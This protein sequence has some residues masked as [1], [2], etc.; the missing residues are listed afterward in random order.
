MRRD[1]PSTRFSTPTGLLDNFDPALLVY[2]GDEPPLVDNTTV[3]PTVTPVTKRTPE[4]FRR[5][6]KRANL[7]GNPRQC[8]FVGEDAHEREVAS[9]AGWRVCP[10]PL[11]VNEVLA[12][13]ALRFVRLTVPPDRLR[14]PW[15]DELQKRPVVPQQFAGENGGTVYALTSDEAAGELGA[16]GFEVDLLGEAGL[17]ETADLYLLR[18]DMA[19]QSGFLSSRGEAARTFAAT[20]GGQR[21]LKYLPDGTV[22]AALSGDR[23]PDGVH[24]HGARHGH[25]VKL[26]PDPLLWDESPPTG[27]L[28]RRAGLTAR[29]FGAVETPAEITRIAAGEMR[30]AVERYSGLRPLDGSQA[31]KVTSRHIRHADNGRVVTQL[32]A[33]LEAAGQGRL[34]VRLHRFTHAGLPLFNVEAELT[35]DSP[36]LVLITA[37]LDSTAAE[38]E[39]YDPA[40]DPAPG[41]DDD[42]SGVA[43]VLTIA[44]RFATLAATATPARTVRF[45]LFNAEEQG[46][47]G[48]QAY[49][50]RSKSRGEAI[51]A[52][53]QMDMI[54]FNKLAPRS[55]EVH[56]GFEGAPAVEAR[57]RR[58]AE[59]LR[60]IAPRVSPDLP[61]AQIYDSATAPEGDPAAGRS[62]HA[63]FQAQGYAACVVSEDFFVG[64][65][66]NGPLPEANPNYHGP[67]DTFIDDVYAAD[68]ARALAAAAWETAS[69]AETLRARRLSS[70][71]PLEVTMPATREYDSRKRPASSAPAT[72]AALVARPA[73]AGRTNTMTGSPA[74]LAA[75]PGPQADKTFVERAVDFMKSQPVLTGFAGMH[76]PEFT[77]DPVVQKTSAGAAVVNLKQMFQGLP[78]FQMARS[79]R[80][81]PD[82]HIM[83]AAG[84]SASIP[85]GTSTDPKLGVE[86]AVFKAA[87]HIAT[88]GCGRARP[89]HVR[90]GEFRWRPST[91][92]GSSPRSSP[93]SRFRPDRPCSTRVRSRIQSRPIW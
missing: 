28:K 36:E 34:Q 79:V 87:S 8:L 56:A 38:H 60:D 32:T 53:W 52:V 5:A 68:I 16:M 39:P 25:T 57:S 88:T 13:H 73:A 78:V 72:R 48:S 41:A 18:D 11:L 49:A 93:V 58:L 55:W 19:A 15:R 29:E 74:I 80:F 23:G 69:H 50:R 30:D 47:I 65:G 83:D 22:V 76:T 26:T 51:V 82:G 84:D 71:S 90:A 1:R 33:D 9:T 77:P 75:A 6:A 40:A 24:F 12:G 43:A 7:D 54:G 63:P 27:P 81:S 31:A 42:A 70:F 35:G 45:V 46:L 89:R 91:S 10:H 92:P 4:I 21:I 2:S 59:L 17:P 86:D 64:P 67:G 14:Q 85:S 62:D 66:T 20:D 44:K 61:E 37:H 3:P